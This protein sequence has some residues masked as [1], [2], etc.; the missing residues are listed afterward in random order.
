M[1]RWAE[2]C[3]VNYNE[4]CYSLNTLFLTVHSSN[5]SGIAPHSSTDSLLKSS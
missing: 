5:V 3:T 1:G 2:G 4:Y